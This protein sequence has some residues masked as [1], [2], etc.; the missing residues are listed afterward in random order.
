MRRFSRSRQT[1]PPRLRLRAEEHKST[2]Y[3]LPRAIAGGLTEL[4]SGFGG[5]VLTFRKGRTLPLITSAECKFSASWYASGL[6]AAGDAHV[7][8]YQSAST[9]KQIAKTRYSLHQPLFATERQSLSSQ[10]FYQ[11]WMQLR[12]AALLVGSR[13][14]RDAPTNL[15][16]TLFSSYMTLPERPRLIFPGPPVV[17]ILCLSWLYKSSNLPIF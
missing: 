16:C 4:R 7:D 8:L 6:G 13:K 2:S 15:Y 5:K 1:H 9:S 10:L 11:G 17:S 12:I 3:F 14:P